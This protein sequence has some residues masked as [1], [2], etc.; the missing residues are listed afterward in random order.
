LNSAYPHPPL[1]GNLVLSFSAETGSYFTLPARK[2]G[3]LPGT[4]NMRLPRYV[5]ER[6]AREAI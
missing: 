3:F 1:F 5:G 6:L 2:E 4:S